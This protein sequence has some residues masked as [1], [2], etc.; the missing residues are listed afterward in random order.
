MRP[1]A[2]NFAEAKIA[3]NIDAGRRQRTILTPLSVAGLLAA[4][5]FHWINTGA[6]RDLLGERHRPRPMAR[7]QR[8]RARLAELFTRHV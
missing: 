5:Q 3:F 7:Q 6:R 1:K 8:S 2:R 4:H